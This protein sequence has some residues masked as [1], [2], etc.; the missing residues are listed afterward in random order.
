MQRACKTSIFLNFTCLT[1]KHFPFPSEAIHPQ[2]IRLPPLYLT[3]GT[4]NSGK[5][6]S[7]DFPLVYVTPGVPKICKKQLK[8]H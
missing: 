7:T 2:I 6:A 5:N 4:I 8:S 3:V 1:Q